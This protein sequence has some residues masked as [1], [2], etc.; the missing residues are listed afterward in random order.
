MLSTRNWGFYTE[1][2]YIALFGPCEF[3]IFS[4]PLNALSWQT[5]LVYDVTS[6]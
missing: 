1:A 4:I 2:A 3:N 5:S 6:Y